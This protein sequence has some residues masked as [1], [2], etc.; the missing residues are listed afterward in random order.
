MAQGVQLV[1]F[2]ADET[3]YADGAELDADNPSCS[4]ICEVRRSRGSRLRW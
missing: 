2:D 4:M 1:T 3:I